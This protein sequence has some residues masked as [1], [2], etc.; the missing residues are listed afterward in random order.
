MTLL[1]YLKQ[2][3]PVRH[4]IRTCGGCLLQQEHRN[5]PKKVTEPLLAV[6]L[7]IAVVV[8]VAAVVRMLLSSFAKIVLFSLWDHKILLC[9]CRCQVRGRKSREEGKQPVGGL[10]H[11]PTRMRGGALSTSGETEGTSSLFCPIGSHGIDQKRASICCT[12]TDRAYYRNSRAI[13]VFFQY[14][15]M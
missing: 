4:R 5:A 9:L 6:G 7:S 8:V 11:Q 13:D 1:T 15:Y 12:W 3:D 10:I 14:R 2:E